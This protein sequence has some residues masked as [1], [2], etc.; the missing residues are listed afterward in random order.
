[1][2]GR[3]DRVGGGGEGHGL[4]GYLVVF[5]SSLSFC[6]PL[7]RTRYLKLHK[8]TWGVQ[9]AKKEGAFSISWVHYLVS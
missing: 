7:L 5:L 1:M 6:L 2:D 4:G 9:I 8:V 3:V